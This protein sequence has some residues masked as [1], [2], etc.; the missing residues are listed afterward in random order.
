MSSLRVLSIRHLLSARS[1]S[2]STHAVLLPRQVRWISVSQIRAAEIPD[3]SQLDTVAQALQ[4]SKAWNAISKNPE[5]QQLFVETAQVLKEEGVDL[6]KPS[7]FTLLK[8]S[9]VREQMMK[10]GQAFSAAGLDMAS[11]KELAELAQNALKDQEQNSK[12]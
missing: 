10:M 6:A 2:A 8:N 12:K 1:L 4:G 7:M 3:K 5:I 9:R 11:M